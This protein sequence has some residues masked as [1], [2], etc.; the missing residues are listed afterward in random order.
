MT[1]LELLP[2]PTDP[3]MGGV[4]VE[5]DA[6]LSECG[7]YRF[8]LTRV[9][10]PA[11]ALLHWLMLN[12]STA[13][14]RRDDAT[15]RRCV[16]YAM[17]WGFGGIVIRNLFALRATSPAVLRTHHDPVGAGNDGW[18]V[19]DPQRVMTIAAWGVNG[20]YLGRDRVVRRQLA[21]AGIRLWH[22]GLNA[23]GQPAHPLQRRTTP[24]EP[25]E[26]AAV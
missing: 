15:V 25:I 22:L 23:G 21:D 5:R 6:V 26:W 9:W 4:P 16:K 3:L 17:R 12:P 14:K 19:T 13:D 11:L 8:E 18:I 2:P 10:S 20:T 7:S 1:T 24:A